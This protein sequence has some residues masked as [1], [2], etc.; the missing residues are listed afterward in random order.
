L[1]PNR[2]TIN[3]SRLL[4]TV[5]EI[6][7]FLLSLDEN[8]IGTG[9]VCY[10]EDNFELT[11]SSN[12]TSN[13]TIQWLMNIGNRNAS[14]EAVKGAF[15]DLNKKVE[16][17]KRVIDGFMPNSPDDCSDEVQELSLR[18]VDLQM[19][20]SETSTV[21]LKQLYQNYQDSWN[22][23][24]TPLTLY[25]KGVSSFKIIEEL[26]GSLIEKI[27]H[28]RPEF[29]LNVKLRQEHPNADTLIGQRDQYRQ[30]IK[31]T[32]WLPEQGTVISDLLVRQ[33]INDVFGPKPTSEGLKLAAKSLGLPRLAEPI[34]P[35]R[36]EYAWIPV[37][38]EID[39]DE[40]IIL[41]TGVY[42]TCERTPKRSDTVCNLYYIHYDD[43]KQLVLSCGAIDNPKKAQQVAALLVRE[44]DK[45]AT[46]RVALHQLNSFFTEK[47]LIQNVHSLVDFLEGKLE[48]SMPGKN[49]RVLHFNTAFNA[50]TALPFFNEDL[51]SVNEINIDS[52]GQLLQCVN[53]DLHLLVAQAQTTPD[54]GVDFLKDIVDDLDG[55]FFVDS[56]NLGNDEIDPEMLLSVPQPVVFALLSNLS[57]KCQSVLELV[58]KIRNSKQLLRS[59]LQAFQQPPGISSSSSDSRDL[60]ES[61]TSSSEPEGS[62]SRSITDS[63]NLQPDLLSRTPTPVRDISHQLKQNQLE[64]IQ[65]LKNVAVKIIPELMAFFQKCSE[66]SSRAPIAKK[67]ILILSVLKE[68][69][70]VQL[71]IPG[72]V[73]HS[74]SS[75]IELFFLL[76]R[77]LNIN[78]IIKCKSG[79]DRSG[80][81]RAISDAQIEME[82]IIFERI[83]QANPGSDP[84]WAKVQAS[85][86]I[87]RMIKG[88]D[89]NRGTLFVE[90]MNVIKSHQIKPAIDERTWENAVPAQINIKEKL[91]EALS[92][93]DLPP[94]DLQLLKDTEDY[95][96]LVNKHLIVEILRTEASTGAS[97][98]KYQHSVSAFRY[99]PRQ[100]AA[101]PHVLERMAFFIQTESGKY[102]QMLNFSPPL[103]SWSNPTMSFT[104]LGMWLIERLSQLRG[105]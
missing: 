12:W 27:A 62:S 61:V 8:D 69:Y 46:A 60:T 56:E 101:N 33:S 96:E 22:K 65:E 53:E 39:E 83:M 103:T 78:P 25:N 86:Q 58:E 42:G 97:G 44:L 88:F 82:R 36:G 11:P 87:L 24:K 5:D 14:F 38:P 66:G 2:G 99:D 26:E 51:K 67:A 93:K 10:D 3:W 91:F 7:R 50:A 64:L 18:L 59:G 19:I 102:I 100:V 15:F 85:E 47:D 20:V 6:Q 76:Y 1:T 55:F 4:V 29:E 37:R 89:Q 48:T 21:G 30:T 70:Q 13:H 43:V 23:E 73:K 72:G 74:R 105:S 57:E 31:A 40:Q 79:L 32:V 16:G 63:Q 52:M 28:H 9:F 35:H 94:D 17:L 77:L 98:L 45:C 54:D 104:P 75:E 34:H 49:V 90:I 84:A 71:K 95:L 80:D 81:V 41:T 68:I 92:Q